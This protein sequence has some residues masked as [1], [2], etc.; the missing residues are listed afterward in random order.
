M[1][2]RP[3]RSTRTDTLFPYTTLFRSAVI[4]TPS[5]LPFIDLRISTDSHILP[6]SRSRGSPGQPQPPWRSG[7]IRADCLA[8]GLSA[9][10]DRADHAHPSHP[11]VRRLDRYVCICLSG[12]CLGRGA[13][14]DVAAEAASP[15]GAVFTL[16]ALASGSL[17][18]QP[19]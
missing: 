10:R 13:D 17:W 19:T 7:A 9:R 11:C 2:R 15:V 6:G 8:A 18:G 3:P 4:P 14:L 12:A 16:L 1:I 5:A